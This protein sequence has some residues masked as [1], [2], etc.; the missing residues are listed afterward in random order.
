LIREC[1]TSI[2]F[3]HQNNNVIHFPQYAIQHQKEMDRLERLAA[4]QEDDDYKVASRLNSEEEE[5]YNSKISQKNIQEKDDLKMTRKIEIATTRADHRR[6]KYVELMRERTGRTVQD[7]WRE[8]DPIAE[9]V[10]GGICVTLLLPDIKILS[11]KLS[12]KRTVTVEATR[13]PLGSE[14]LPL[15]P[16]DSVFDTDFEIEGKPD[17]LTQSDI[18]YDYSSENGI[19]HVYIENVHLGVFG[20]NEKEDTKVVPKSLSLSG[21]KNKFTKIF[22]GLK[23]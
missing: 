5:M 17:S 23:N 18:S 10:M 22:S 15:N 21:I 3:F 16:I 2:F 1:F 20:T 8:V 14:S 19:L 11:V 7:L 13:L 4:K 6:R 9:D 12:R